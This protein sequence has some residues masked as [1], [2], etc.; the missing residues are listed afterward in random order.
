MADDE[1][2]QTPSLMIKNESAN[3]ESH[4]NLFVRDPEMATL[5]VKV[6]DQLSEFTLGQ[7]S[8]SISQ[9]FMRKDFENELQTFPLNGRLDFEIIFALK[10]NA[11]KIPLEAK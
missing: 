10:L 5:D 7:Y 4:L 11:L 9:L 3:Y 8:Y 1:I 2:K 6:V